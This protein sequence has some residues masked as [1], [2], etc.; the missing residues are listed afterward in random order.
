M[1][2][3]TKSIKDQQNQMVEIS[4]QQASALKVRAKRMAVQQETKDEEKKKAKN[5]AQL[6]AKKRADEAPMVAPAQKR[7]KEDV[8]QDKTNKKVGAISFSDAKL[9]STS[10]GQALRGLSMVNDAAVVDILDNGKM[11]AK[12][13]K[14]KEQQKRIITGEDKRPVLTPEQKKEKKELK[15]ALVKEQKKVAREER[16]HEPVA[17][18]PRE[19]RVA[20]AKERALKAD[21]MTT[22]V[23]VN[24]EYNYNKATQAPVLRQYAQQE[25]TYKKSRLTLIDQSTQGLSPEQRNQ[26]VM[27]AF[28]Q[29]LFQ[30]TANNPTKSLQTVALLNHFGR[31][32]NVEELLERAKQEKAGDK[33]FFPTPLRTTPY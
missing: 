29:A 10:L 12:D 22:A 19:A 28:H 33:K 18:L 17:A 24:P 14:V 32:K 31:G 1:P 21:R 6:V 25:Q 26:I 27:E 13:E 7:V 15:K 2:K 9:I 16:K 8:A 20:V 4:A 3:L 23:V 5:T 30:L 11:L